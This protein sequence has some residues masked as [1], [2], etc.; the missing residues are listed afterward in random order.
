M[1]ANSVTILLQAAE[2][3]QWEEADRKMY[4]HALDYAPG[5]DEVRLRQWE[6]LRDIIEDGDP[7]DIHRQIL[8]TLH[9]QLGEW[10]RRGEPRS[11]EVWI[12]S[13]AVPDDLPDAVRELLNLAD[14]GAYI[15]LADLQSTPISRRLR[16]A[17]AAHTCRND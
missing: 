6:E 9:T 2:V 12:K 8:R 3:H 13:K 17:L 5:M 15:D 14:E 10:L 1:A 16:E 11:H 7:D 4:L